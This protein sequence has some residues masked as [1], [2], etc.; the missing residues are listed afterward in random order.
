MFKVKINKL[1]PE[2]HYTVYDTRTRTEPA[3]Y[4]HNPDITMTEFLIYHSGVWKWINAND[5]E[6]V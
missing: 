4:R 2:S 3:A 6:P 5:C 1:D